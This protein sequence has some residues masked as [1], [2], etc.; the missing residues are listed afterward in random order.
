MDDE[1]KHWLIENLKTSGNLIETS[2]L[3]IELKKEHLLPTQLEIL[4]EIS[5]Q[6]VDDHCIVQT[7]QD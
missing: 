6:M 7:A 5:Q 2:L 4:Y 1:S 3:L